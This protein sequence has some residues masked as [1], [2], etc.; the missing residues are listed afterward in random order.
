MKVKDMKSM[1]SPRSFTF[2]IAIFLLLGTAV[3][4]SQ[5]T[6]FE[7]PADNN[8]EEITEIEAAAA[9]EAE[10]LQS[11]STCPL[12]AII[13]APRE[14]KNYHSGLCLNV[15][16]MGMHNGANV[17]QATNCSLSSSQWWVNGFGFSTLAASHS[18]K[19]LN[20]LN[21]SMSNGGN[22][23]QATDCAGLNSQW[24]IEFVRWEGNRKC[25]P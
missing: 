17:V 22:V 2:L 4:G 3:A 8:E 11:A 15:L 21:S 16:D 12:G 6:A 7:K 24:T 23:V 13:C 9:I 14:I 1:K 10:Q 19:C 18:G 25:S 5:V 20:V